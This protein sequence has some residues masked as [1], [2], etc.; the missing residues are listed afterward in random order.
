MA[1][2][3][4]RAYTNFRGVDFANDASVNV[5]ILTLHK[6]VLQAYVLVSVFFPTIFSFTVIIQFKH[7]EKFFVCL[8]QL[9]HLETDIVFSGFS[10]ALDLIYHMIFLVE[11]RKSA[12][13]VWMPL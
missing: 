3:V 8:A 11:G 9:E 7:M 10:Q 5:S 2:T 6:D 13:K 12:E 4:K 1:T